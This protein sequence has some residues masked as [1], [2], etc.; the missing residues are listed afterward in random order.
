MNLD[1]FARPFLALAICAALAGCATG[2][3]FQALEPV[4][5]DRAQLYVYRPLAFASSVVIHKVRIDGQ[6]SALNLANGSWLR[7]VLSPG[8]HTVS[9]ATYLNFSPASCGAVQVSL[10]PG[11]TAFVANVQKMTQGPNR[12]YIVCTTVSKPRDEALKEM[13]GL[14]SAQ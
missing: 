6:A 12:Q 7:V 4:P 2:P 8:P 13:T 1:H 3:A 10:A 14:S 11:E 9:V 5:T